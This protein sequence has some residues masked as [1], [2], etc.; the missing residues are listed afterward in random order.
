M[1]IDQRLLF[2]R[3]L[4]CL[5]LVCVGMPLAVASQPDKS[6]VAVQYCLDQ[7]DPQT[8]EQAKACKYGSYGA[9][10]HR[11]RHASVRWVKV[12]ADVVDTAQT[13]SI[14][15]APHLLQKIEI[16]DGDT[17]QRLAGPVGTDYPYS[18]EHGLLAGYTFNIDPLALGPQVYYVRMEAFGL[19]YGFVQATLDTQT[20]EAMNQQIGLGTHLG[21]LGLLT[22]VSLSFYVATRS[23]IMGVFGLNM[24]ALLLGVMLGSGLLF[25]NLWPNWPRLNELLFTSVFYLKPALWVLLAQTFLAP[26]QTPA[27]YRPCC[28]AAYLAVLAILL[29]SWIGLTDISNWLMLLFGFTLIPIVQ[30]IAIQ[31]TAEIRRFYKR[32]LMLGYGLLALAIWLTILITI[33]P[34]D[35]PRLPIQFSRLADYI[36]PM[37]LLALVMFHYR[38]TV[39][40]LATVKD[41]NLK[42]KLGLEFAQQVREERKLMVDMLTHEL[43]NPLASISLAMGSLANT[44]KNSDDHVDRRLRNIDQSV[45]SMDAVIERCHLMNQLDQSTLQSRPA[46]ISLNQSLANITA[47]FPDS[48]RIVLSLKG[49]DTFTTDPQFFEMIVSN[50]L[51]NALKYSATNTAVHLNLNRQVLESHPWLVIEVSNQIGRKG[52]PAKEFVFSRFYRHPLAH[53]TAGSGVGLYL[54]QALTKLMQGHI[55]YESSTHTVMFRVQL[56]EAVNDA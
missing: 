15:V 53:D 55:K 26:Y 8:V 41:E 24:L 12:V 10:S 7:E 37:V 9:L 3:I 44:L 52:F 13:L 46:T 35:D 54:V 31:M 1:S 56:P 34:V 30:L 6:S 20:A 4:T 43:K 28:N 14:S 11:V 16:F 40:L 36:S 33:Y 49:M 38:E 25:A 32:V 27:W 19:P 29:F 21:V 2:I 48:E 51:E 22:L 18:A 5:C 42:M 39:T 47:R 50:L 23:H 17:D 45:R